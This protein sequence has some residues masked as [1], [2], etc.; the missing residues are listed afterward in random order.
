MSPITFVHPDA[1]PD[2]IDLALFGVLEL[3]GKRYEAAHAVPISQQK[4]LLL[5][6]LILEEGESVA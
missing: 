1:N 3:T 2:N 5:A 4:H 6:G